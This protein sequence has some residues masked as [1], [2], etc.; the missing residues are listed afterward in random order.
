MTFIDRHACGHE[1]STQVGTN[2][3]P[4]IFSDVETPCVFCLAEQERKEAADKWAARQR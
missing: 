1:E 2:V 3:N 4:K